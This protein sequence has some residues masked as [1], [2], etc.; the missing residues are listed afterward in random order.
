MAPKVKAAESK[1]KAKAI[2]KKA[3]CEEEKG[4]RVPQPDRVEYET[5]VQAIPGAIDKLQQKQAKNSHDNDDESEWG[6][7][8]GESDEGEADPKPS[9]TA[10]AK[11]KRTWTRMTPDMIEALAAVLRELAREGS[12]ALPALPHR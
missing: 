9:A 8:G 4:D 6:D 12:A 11:K 3:E 1:A 7:W 2:G 10:N 5:A